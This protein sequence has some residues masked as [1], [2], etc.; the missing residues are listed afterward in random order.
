MRLLMRER[1][2]LFAYAW[3]IVRDMH[4]AEDVFQ[5]VAVLAIEKHAEMREPEHLLAWSR[6][7]IRLKALE[8]R[9]RQ[10]RQPAIL[11]SG[12]LELLEQ[13][14]RRSHADDAGD[15]VDALQHCVERLAPNARRLVTL[16]YVEGL[17][18]GAIAEKLQRNVDTVYKA[19]SRAHRALAECVRQQIQ[20]ATSDRPT[21]PGQA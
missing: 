10:G 20:H 9:R 1:D 13:D 14:W 5:E 4:L 19:I 15:V 8:S 11:S 21:E 17:A 18:S 6:N 12:T 3:S 7:A 2:R 16:R